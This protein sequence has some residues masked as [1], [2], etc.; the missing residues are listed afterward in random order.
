M[1]RLGLAMALADT[2]DADTRVEQAQ[3][4]ID[5]SVPTTTSTLKSIRMVPARYMS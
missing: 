3:Q 5:M 2:P 1:V 4:Q